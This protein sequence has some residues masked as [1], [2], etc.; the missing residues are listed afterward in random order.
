MAGEHVVPA[1]PHPLEA[2]AGPGPDDKGLVE[3]ARPAPVRPGLAVQVHPGHRE[4]RDEHRE[5]AE[6]EDRATDGKA[7]P[8]N[9]EPVLMKDDDKQ[10][11]GE[12]GHPR[13]LC[14]LKGPGDMRHVV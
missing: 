7:A 6:E 14:H 10:P 12:Q 13:D 8:P 1:G 3:S 5:A 2:H 4:A 9:D 11:D